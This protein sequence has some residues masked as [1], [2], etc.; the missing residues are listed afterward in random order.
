VTGTPLKHRLTGVVRRLRRQDD[1]GSQPDA[2]SDSVIDDLFNKLIV[3]AV[4][5]GADSEHI[6]A[7]LDQATQAA[8]EVIAERLQ[9]DAPRMLRE[10]RDFRRGFEQRLQQRWG[11][12]LDL[13]EC[14]RVCCLESGE[15]F[16]SRYEPRNDDSDL[17]HEALTLLHAR[18]CLVTSEVQGLLRT[19]HAAG[20][21]A[22]WRT[23][24]E[25]A[26]IAFTLGE[27]EPALSERFL[28]HRLVERYKDAV[29]YQR[30][31]EAIGYERF[32]GEEIAELQ[33]QYD[34]VVARFGGS[35]KNDWGW[36]AP[37][38]PA[39]PPATLA[40][41]AEL[42]GLDHLKPWFRLSSHDIHSGATGAMHV[43]DLYGQGD[44]MLAGPSNGGLA[45]PGNGALISLY[46]VTSALLIYGG[47]GGPRAQD[48]LALKAIAKLLDQAQ[49]TFME[50]HHALQAEDATIQGSRNRGEPDGAPNS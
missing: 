18:A 28:L 26:V 42:V 32:S 30:Y 48:L 2:G 25:L 36:A 29:V 41:L 10:H 5:R 6:T 39:N 47:T 35:F 3:E 31:C 50:I 17:K 12:A 40:K 4:E 15:T 49:V 22:R 33:R 24:Y 43:R 1:P 7:A 13:Y 27:N 14:V 45:D 9:A 16:H 20:A 34:E 46:Q 37:L 11:P 21:Q 38:F 23:L 8:A 44:A 19:G